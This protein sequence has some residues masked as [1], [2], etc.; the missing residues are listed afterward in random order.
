MNHPLFPSRFASAALVVGGFLCLAGFFGRPVAIDK[1]FSVND[2]VAIGATP[3][4]WVTT[5]RMLVFGL[6]VRL[7]GL[8]ALATFAR[9][10][11]AKSLVIPGV[12]I[13]S[14]G[15]L[16]SAMAQGYYMDIALH[17]VWRFTQETS[18]TGRETILA[19]WLAT[20]E[21]ASCLGRMGSMFLGLGTAIMAIGLRDELARWQTWSIG[22]LAFGTMMGIFLAP[23]F[24]PVEV[25]T[26]VA[27][28]VA[29]GVLGMAVARRGSLN[30]E[31]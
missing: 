19:S 8:V 23:G 27:L 7:A 1:S 15:L 9:S 4:M 22:A 26:F 6:F 31:T 3:G 16:V 30:P 10:S 17:G 25:S 12:A 13:G 29:H 20:D 18:V 21:W 2:I 28:I 11:G 14:A 24:R 5:F